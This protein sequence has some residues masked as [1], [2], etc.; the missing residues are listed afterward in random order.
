MPASVVAAPLIGAGSSL[1][2]AGIASRGQSRA[3]DASM[4]ANREALAFE[5]EREMRRRQEYDQER[6][7]QRAQFEA[8][9]RRLAPYRQ[10]S[11]SVLAKYGIQIPMNEPAPSMAGA[12]SPAVGVPPMP[13]VNPFRGPNGY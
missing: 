6:A 10:A 1:L 3:A 11:A 4:Q 8:N 7:E 5:R 2:G 13:P 12:P 9:E